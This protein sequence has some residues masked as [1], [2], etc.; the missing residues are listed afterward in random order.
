MISVFIKR[1]AAPATKR[2]YSSSRS[3]EK[4]QA[5]DMV[6]VRECCKGG[7]QQMIGPLDPKQAYSS[8]LGILHH[9]D[10]I[11]MR[12]RERV[13]CRIKDIPSQTQFIIQH[14]TLEDYIL[15]C[16]RKTTPIYPKDAS[17]IV[18]MLDISPGDCILE[19]GTGNAS[20]TMHLAR[21]V[22][23][24]GRVHTV[25]RH[26]ETSRHARGLV[27]QFQR[28][29]LLPQSTF[30]VGVLSETIESIVA[31]I[32]NEEQAVADGVISSKAAMEKPMFD[33]MALD[34][35]MPWTQLPHIHRFLKT[36]RFAVCYLPSMSQVMDLV[37]A[38]KMWPLLVED[39]VEVDWRSW[40]VRLAT[41]R[42]NS[43]AT[44]RGEAQ[45]GI[46]GAMVCRPTHTPTGHT[47]F[48]VKLRR[49]IAAA[50]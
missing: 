50:N 34:M 2:R 25:E 8:R 48:L 27:E 1:T 10:I 17:A 23:H 20:L 11:G 7:K 6:L 18:A 15:R 14:P 33:G 49:L 26:A 28:G 29:K 43:D 30:H 9:E 42:D 37:R 16:K 38:C 21:A 46:E 39:I 22:G 41:V 47:A 12:P 13:K 36:D 5:G 32:V 45:A 24:A 19:A 44:A 31:S 40:D 3:P 35:P 4:F